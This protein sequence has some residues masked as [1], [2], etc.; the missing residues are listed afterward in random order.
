MINAV[1]DT[2]VLLSALKK[3]S[4]ARK[5]LVALAD[6]KFKLFLSALLREELERTVLRPKI[7]KLVS[8]MDGT[9]LVTII[10]KAATIVRPSHPI[11]SCRD[12]KDNMLLECA[13]EAGAK[14]LVTFDSDLLVLNPF[15]NIAIITPAEF[16]KRLGR[17]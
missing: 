11:T 6:N 7:Q 1:V 17:S 2:N 3:T 9:L 5:I 8:D 14:Y 4:L 13:L 15:Q 12:P 10:G 16:L